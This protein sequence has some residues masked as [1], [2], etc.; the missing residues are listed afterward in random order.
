MIKRT[1]EIYSSR[2]TGIREAFRKLKVDGLIVAD[3]TN[4]RYLSGFTGSA[5]L[6]LI[7]A[8]D[9]FFITDFRYKEQ[10]EKEVRGWDIIIE[11]G[12]RIETA[13]SLCKK[14][15]I[16]KLALE[17]SVSYGFFRKISRTTIR[18]TPAEGLVEKLRSMKDVDEISAI[19]E[20]I[21]RAEY[22][23]L[24]VKPHI[25]TGIR[26]T[27]I[28]GKLEEQLKKKGCRRI[29]FD[30]I[31]ASGPNTA[32][33][34]ARPGS[35]KLSKGDLVIIDWGGEAKGYYSDMTRSFL[36]GGGADI[37]RKKSLY[38]IVLMANKTA[39]RL[40][41]PGIES[42]LIDNAARDVIT[43][44]GYGEFFG[45]GTG[46]GVGMQV[47]ESPRITWNR[48]ETIERKMV[49][50]VEPGIYVPG[51]GGVRIEDMVMVGNKKASLLTSLPKKLEIL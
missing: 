3:I 34:H 38:N 51:L 47:H 16:R 35:R 12:D 29:A 37:G 25:K 44:A 7:T 4:V 39:I 42:V 33:P 1:T 9:L 32:M 24:E 45:H 10:S 20:A 31:V 46:H 8:K 15:G 48:Y 5:G 26:E 11:K 19:K 6:L 30:I 2:I 13:H 27:A 23:F 14:K 50:T 22:A 28:A 43:A 40:V 41:A 21:S 18:I 49:F 36:M 17:D